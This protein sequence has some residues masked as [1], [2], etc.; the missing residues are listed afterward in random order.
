M[1]KFLKPLFLLLVLVFAAVASRPFWPS[2]N[3]QAPTLQ[4]YE[5]PYTQAAFDQLMAEKRPVLVRAW[6]SWCPTCKAQDK[7]FAKLI[8]AEPKLGTA[9]HLILDLSAL[10]KKGGAP[11]P[12][13]QAAAERFKVPGTGYLMG[14]KEGRAVIRGSSKDPDR[15]EAVLRSLAQ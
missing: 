8:A 11:A 5:Q 14:F 3:A 10:N 13:V 2:A 15:L 4:A 6:A 1:M 7:A 9:R 12:E